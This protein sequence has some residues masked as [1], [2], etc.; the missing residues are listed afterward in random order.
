MPCSRTQQGNPGVAR[1][2]QRL[3]PESDVF[4]TRPPCPRWDYFRV[5]VD[6][7]VQ[8]CICKCFYDYLSQPKLI[9]PSSLFLLTLFQFLDLHMAGDPS[10]FIYWKIGNFYT[11]QFADSYTTLLE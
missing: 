2:P 5:T 4:T 6:R 7:F 10:L 9:D 3:D 8:F 11:A 1:T